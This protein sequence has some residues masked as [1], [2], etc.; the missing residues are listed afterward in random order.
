MSGTCDKWSSDCVARCSASESHSRW[1]PV[2]L[3]I[4]Q[5]ITHDNYNQLQSAVR[6]R[7]WFFQSAGESGEQSAA[8][9]VVFSSEIGRVRGECGFVCT[10]KWERLWCGFVCTLNWARRLEYIVEFVWEWLG[11]KFLWRYQYFICW[12]SGAV[13]HLYQLTY[14]SFLLGCTVTYSKPSFA[15]GVE[16]AVWPPRSQGISELQIHLKDYQV[17]MHLAFFHRDVDML[18]IQKWS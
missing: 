10:L 17:Y 14:S 9:V 11:P 6:V 1:R 3:G 15:A 4:C 13:F 7:N 12:E 16:R 18:Q 2:L 5:S 8:V